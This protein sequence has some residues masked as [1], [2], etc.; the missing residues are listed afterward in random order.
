ME[1][2]LLPPLLW[3]VRIAQLQ[4][5]TKVAK[6]FGVTRAAL[7]QNLKTL[8]Q[9]LGVTLIYRTTRDMSL[10]EE[11]RLLYES[12]QPALSSVD[13]AL[14]NI[15]QINNEP[16]GLLR[17]NTSRVVAKYIIEPHLSE[18]LTRYPKLKI[19]LITDDGL[20]NIIADGCDAGVRLGESLVEHVVAIPITPMLEMAVVGSP[21]YFEIYGTPTQPSELVNHNCLG[22]RNSTSHSLYSWEFTE[23]DGGDFELQP[24]G[25]LI[26]NDDEG[27]IRA[28]VNGIGLIQHIDFAVREHIENG[29][30][31]RVL[32]EW[33]PPFTGFFLYVPS[34]E[35]MPIKTRILIDFLKEKRES[36]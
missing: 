10:T 34:R 6:E 32:D 36:W 7:S 26:T 33:C 8:E 21:Q 9:K 17:I 1:P 20:A 24:N 5:F 35:N 29:K 13:S 2:S 31:V 25:K 4:S 18:F 28:A 11:G 30:L 27:M 23:P 12:L 22:F 3:F 16:T 14:R 15:G 19:E